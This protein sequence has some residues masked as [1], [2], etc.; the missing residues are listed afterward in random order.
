MAFDLP[1]MVL[2][3]STSSTLFECA[4]ALHLFLESGDTAQ[5]RKRCEPQAQNASTMYRNIIEPYVGGLPHFAH[6]LAPTV[7]TTCQEVRL[8]DPVSH[9][10]KLVE[11]ENLIKLLLE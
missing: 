3:S 5:N 9:A 6:L 10:P 2:M 8:D 4:L 11:N 7:S 1:A